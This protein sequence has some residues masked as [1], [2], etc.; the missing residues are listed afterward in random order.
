MITLLAFLLALG[1]LV[2]VHEYG[3][4]RVAVACGV[5]VLRFSVG[6]GQVL[7]RWQKRPEDTEFVVC[8]LPLGGYVR[9]LD[10]REGPVA[11]EERA[12]ALNAQPV[13]RRMAIVLA[14]PVANL[15]LAIVLLAAVHWIGTQETQAVLSSPPAG[16]LAQEAG[17]RSGDQV[18]ES[19]TDGQHWTPVR[20][21]SDLHWRLADA[22]MQSE[23]LRL[24]V[25]DLS[26]ASERTV[27]LP[28][29]RLGSREIDAGVMQQ[30]G[31]S[32]WRAPVISGVLEGG[33]AA[34]A[35]V[36]AG[37]RVLRVDDV[38]VVDAAHLESLIRERG[39]GGTPRSMTWHLER[40]LQ[41]LSIELTPVID[42]KDQV[43][44]VS[45]YLGQGPE[46]VLV[47]Y[48]F[49]DGLREAAGDTWDRSTMTLR[50]LGRMLVG[51]AS[52]KNLSG[53]LTMADYA[54]QAVRRG[55]TDYLVYL[56]LLSVSLGVLNLLPLPILD[57]GH[58]MYY[59][60][61]VLTGRPVSGPWLERLQRGGMVILLLAMF[62][63]LF[64]DV[65]RYLGQH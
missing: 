33:P 9:M 30:L 24:R 57:G 27:A 34:R 41:T 7:W 59:L 38:P 58:L 22:L 42:P 20:S 4:Y 6:F 52:V 21:L 54:G 2:V 36:Q 14:G 32:M 26:G 62:L 19:S 31:L 44:R 35:G 1:V 15:L 46:K 18:R 49:V 48:G 47:R 40:G 64:N 23:T 53:A 3:H 8:A 63:A 29:A 65:T 43:A 25:T 12:R 50:M 45:V 39:A 5:K 51:E 37:D 55:L 16:S 56:A 60:F 11:P 13:W 10:E 17:L 61:E 28:L